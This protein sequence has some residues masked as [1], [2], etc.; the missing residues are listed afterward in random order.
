[1]VR[2][3]TTSLLRPSSRGLD[4]D[5]PLHACPFWSYGDRIYARSSQGNTVSGSV[6]L[7]SASFGWQL[8]RGEAK[9][10][11]RSNRRD[12]AETPGEGERRMRTRIDV[13]SGARGMKPAARRLGAVAT[14][15]AL[16]GVGL[17]VAAAPAHADAN[18]TFSCKI[19]S[20]SIP[21]ATPVVMSLS[22]NAPKAG[23]TVKATFNFSAGYKTGPVIVGAQKTVGRIFVDANGTAIKAQ[24]TPNPK[25]LLPSTP[26]SFAPISVSF[27]AKTGSNVLKVTKFEFRYI[28]GPGNKDID[29]GL[30][31]I[32]TPTSATT[33]ETFTAASS[34]TTKTGGTTP[35]GTKTCTTNGGTNGTNLPNSCQTGGSVTTVSGA[36][37]L[38]TGS[39][40]VQ[41]QP[42]AKP[43][44]SLP[45]TGPDSALRTGI[46][47]A[48]ALQLGL[49]MAI[50][51]SR[52]SRRKAVAR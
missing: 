15:T 27:K 26:F 47:A 25:V 11:G 31:T 24:G 5:I 48:A 44:T 12:V 42:A 13:T 28:D 39:T 32:C 3:P 22:P 50:R 45:R 9:R 23:Q 19:L 38:Q 16:M 2:E 14:A 35:G 33:V 7:S 21:W 40:K 29:T 17:A 41:Q 51:M 20:S 49:I 10:E 34:S 46:A 6:S 8:E 52:K 4:F 37:D 18:M 30:D 43:R 1:M 36:V